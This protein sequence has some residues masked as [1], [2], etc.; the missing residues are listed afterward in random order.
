MSATPAGWT[1]YG[2]A[3]ESPEICEEILTKMAD[4]GWTVE[5]TSWEEVLQFLGTDE[6][7]INKLALVSK[8]KPDGSWKHRL[9][10]DL[11][12]SGVNLLVNQGER[13]ILPRVQDVLQDAAELAKPG[14][15]RSSGP[16]VLLV[17][18]DISDAFHCVPR[19]LSLSL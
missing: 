5:L 16:P 4:S 17:G 13:V 15:G 7:A 6:V 3:E 14:D 11:L 10:W 2:S 8:Q 9:I 18:T 19:S 1:N 12:R